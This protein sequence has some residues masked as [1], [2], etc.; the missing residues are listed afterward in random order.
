[1][2]YRSL[3]A[4]P[5]LF[6]VAALT[7]EGGAAPS[8]GSAVDGELYLAAQYKPAVPVIRRFT[9]RESRLTTPSRLFRLSPGASVLSLDPGQASAGT[10][11][12]APL[13]RALQ[14]SQNFEPGYV[15]SYGPSVYG[16]SGVLGYSKA[17]V[18]VELEVSFENFK[19]KRFGRPMLRGSHEYFAAGG[20]AIGGTRHAA[21]E[22]GAVF[23]NSA[24]SAGSAL[25]NICRSFPAGP[26][27]GGVA[28]YACLGGGAEFLDI[29]GTASTR[30]AY[31]AK[32][33]A[34]LSLHPRIGAFAAGYYRGTLE[35]AVRP[36]PVVA[37]VPRGEG[38]SPGQLP[39]E[40]SVGIQY[41]GV[42][43]GIRV[44]L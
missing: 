4:L 34:A 9:V 44:S 41:L 23:M 27:G 12:D 30:F 14:G 32:V 5:F 35:R 43:A 26:Y 33:G 17:G 22:G 8:L 29:L 42:E 40:S 6:F 37:L 21:L 1:M 38:G 7:T 39:F 19:V 16:A 18:G 3:F 28:P 2:S 20:R 25:V 11:L 24:I 10:S 15:P 13:L 36:L 31:Q